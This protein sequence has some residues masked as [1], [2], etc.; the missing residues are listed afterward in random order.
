M[1][2]IGCLS[3]LLQDFSLENVLTTINPP[4]P[5]A[6][7]MYTLPGS[8]QLPSGVNQ[9]SFNI[10]QELTRICYKASFTFDFGAFDPDGDSLV[11]Y[12]CNAYNRG[13]ST[14]SANVSPSAPPY[15]PVC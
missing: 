12:Y 1:K 2:D 3:D 11:Y 8:S 5:K 9:Q 13:N 15:Q 14:N 6:Q 10:S 7:L 4:G